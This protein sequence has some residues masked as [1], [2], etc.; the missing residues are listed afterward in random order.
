MIYFLTVNFVQF[1]VMKTPGS[2]SAMTKMLDPD[3]QRNQSGFA[4]LFKAVWYRN[5]S[6]N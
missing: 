5:R 1:L 4:T 6:K 2:G 3:P